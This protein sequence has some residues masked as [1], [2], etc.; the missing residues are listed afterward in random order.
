METLMNT[1]LVKPADGRT[2]LNPDNGMRPLGAAGESVP[3]TMY[4]RHRIADG[5]VVEVAAEPADIPAPPVSA[6]SA[7]SK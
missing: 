6:R 5:S 1:L 4:W 3:A 7:K 2:V